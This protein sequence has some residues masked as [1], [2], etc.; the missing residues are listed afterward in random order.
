MTLAASVGAAERRAI[1]DALQAAQGHRGRASAALGLS[2]SGLRA[3]VRRLGLAGA[4]A[5]LAAS[6]G[7]PGQTA[8]ATA[9]AAEA[10][11]ER[12]ASA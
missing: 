5:E 10:R 3:A 2:V 4:L 8:A 11:R 7:W 1:L 9:R 6:Q 12:N